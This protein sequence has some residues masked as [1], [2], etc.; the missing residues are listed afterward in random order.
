MNMSKTETEPT[1][2]GKETRLENYRLAIK[3]ARHVFTT[4]KDKFPAEAW[5]TIRKIIFSD[6]LK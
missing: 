3:D 6:K 2:E 1:T 5:E 4:Y